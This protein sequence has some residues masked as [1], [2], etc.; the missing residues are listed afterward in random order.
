MKRNNSNIN[1]LIDHWEGLAPGYSIT[2]NGIQRI[3]LLLKYYSCNEIIEA[4]D[5]S[6]A[7]YLDYISKDEVTEESW[8][9][10]YTKIGNIARVVREKESKPELKDL[11]Y[12]RGILRNRIRGFNDYN[13]SEAIYLLKEAYNK[14]ISID[15]LKLVALRVDDMYD[16]REELANIFMSL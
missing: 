5:I 3:K 14:N 12:I 2:E 9:T 13:N 15:E 8:E 11:F 1:N 7:T 10:A 4:M 6:A 16:F